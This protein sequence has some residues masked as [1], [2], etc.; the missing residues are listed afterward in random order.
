MSA[1]F[2]G[3]ISGTSADGIDAV[4]VEFGDDGTVPRVV[5][6][7]THQYDDRLHHDVESVIAGE[8]MPIAAL[9]ELDARVGEAFGAAA[10]ETLADA[11][12]EPAAV[13]AIGSHG[14]TIGH[15]P[16]AANRSTVQIGDPN[17][18]AARTGIPV[19]ADF[20]RADMA[21]GGQ[22]APFAPLFHSVV[23]ADAGGPCAILN[24]GGIANLTILTN[25]DLIGFDTGPA[26]TL[27]DWWAAHQR[28]G[29]HD[30]GGALA[31]SGE[32]D[33]CLLHR[34]LDDPYFMVAPPKS[35]GREHFNYAWLERRLGDA[36]RRPADVQA[37]LAELSA[38]T[39]GEAFVPYKEGVPRLFACGGG[40]HNHDLMERIARHVAPAKLETTAALGV[41]PNYV[42]GMLFAWLARERIHA[43]SPARLG[44][45]TGATASAVLGGVWLPPR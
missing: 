10:L 35:T 18:I 39:I 31:R 22:G 20:R 11:S 2:L 16:G 28:I 41:D 42:E 21:V 19:V 15:F 14:Q 13:S 12:V 7:H 29:S 45:V 37:T 40:V 26:N 27:L 8:T 4:L 43:R 1:L 23:F 17:R 30:D 25:Q 36:V 6:A 9:A 44:A 38:R 33:G 5:A 34:L 32:V 3:L 24:L